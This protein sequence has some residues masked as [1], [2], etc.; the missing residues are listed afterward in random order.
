MISY[1]QNHEDVVLA[2]ALPKRSGFY[3]DV[4]AGSPTIHSV[5][6]HFY[7]LGWRGVNVEPLSRWHAQLKRARPDDINLEIGLS[8]RPGKLKFYDVSEQAAEESTFSEDV[9]ETLRSRGLDPKIRDVTV[10]TLAQVC[11]SHVRSDI[12][13]LKVDVEGFELNVLMGGSWDR[14]RPRIVVVESTYPG[15]SRLAGEDV[16]EFMDGVGYT[17]VLFDGLN[18]FFVQHQDTEL[19]SVLGV[20]ANVLDRY[21]DSETAELRVRLAEV[22]DSCELLERR[23]VDVERRTAD[24][25]QRAAERIGELEAEG[26]SLANAVVEAKRRQ[27]DLEE[28]LAVAQE[29]LALTQR[30]VRMAHQ[31]EADARVQFEATR[32]ALERVLATDETRKP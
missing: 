29:R 22:R 2:R 24:D 17:V 3:I 26:S 16:V 8:D 10:A 21:E 14:F 25:K 19:H 4:G 30:D 7:R 20:P 27:V 6:N 12:D 1:A 5:T 11:D 23:L 28:R 13:F 9:A 31:Q 18:R 15:T 32:E